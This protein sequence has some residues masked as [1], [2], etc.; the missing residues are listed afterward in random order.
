MHLSKPCNM[1]DLLFLTGST[2]NLKRHLTIG[3]NIRLKLRFLT[4]KKMWRSSATLQI[5]WCSTKDV[6][7]RLQA[8]AGHTKHKQSLCKQNSK[9]SSP[10]TCSLGGISLL[11]HFYVHSDFHLEWQIK[12]IKFSSNNVCSLT[13]AS[14]ACQFKI[15]YKCRK[16][17]AK[18]KQTKKCHILHYFVADS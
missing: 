6:T 3:K 2:P 14:G 18:N 9:I 15:E 17:N 8:T 16:K 11:C 1:T 5:R 13:T 12:I 10:V 4:G 7:Q